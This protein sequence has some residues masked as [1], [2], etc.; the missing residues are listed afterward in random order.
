MQEAMGKK[1][2]SFRPGRVC[3][4]CE[5]ICRR[6]EVRSLMEAGKVANGKNW[7]TLGRVKREVKKE[8]KAGRGAWGRFLRYHCASGL[9][10]LGVPR[11][12]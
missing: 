8:N 12:R 7:A 5:L 3:I 4:R 6:R 2:M 9:S 11:V 1:P 10:C